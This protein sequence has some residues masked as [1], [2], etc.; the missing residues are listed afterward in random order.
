ML[1]DQTPS[2]RERPEPAIPDRPP[3][4]AAIGATDGT[5]AETAGDRRH[6]GS[7]WRR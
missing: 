2:F 4:G 5:I 3:A 6:D 7:P 1:P